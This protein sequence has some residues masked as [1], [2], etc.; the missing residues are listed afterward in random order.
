M[1]FDL[2]PPAIIIPAPDELIR[3][4]NDPALASNLF[5][6]PIGWKVAAPDLLIVLIANRDTAGA[7][8]TW[9]SDWTAFASAKTNVNITGEARWKADAGESSIT[10]TLAN[11]ATLSWAVYRIRGHSGD[12]DGTSSVGNDAASTTPNPPLHN[13]A[14]TQHLW[15]ACAEWQSDNVTEG[16]TVT[17]PTNY[18]GSQIKDGIA[19]QSAIA[20]A[21]RALS[22]TSEDPDVFTIQGSRRW[23]TWTIGIPGAS[24]VVNNTA[25]DTNAASTSHAVTIPAAL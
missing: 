10:L 14:D 3:Y 7:G 8:A 19:N 23:V 1:N 6:P 25:D 20:A 22:A 5:V 13:S 12:P 24:A 16:G 15:I 2:P 18:T 17:Y 11:S 9:P 21:T 4:G